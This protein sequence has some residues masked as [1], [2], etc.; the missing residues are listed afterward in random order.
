MAPVSRRMAKPDAFLTD[1]TG[2][3]EVW[4]IALVRVEAEADACPGPSQLTFGGERMLGAAY[5]PVDDQL[6]VGGDVGGNERTQLFL[7]SGDGTSRH[8]ALTNQPEVIHVFGGWQEDGSASSGWS[9]DGTRI[10]YA[11]NAR[12]PRFFDIYERSVD[13]L[14]SHRACCYETTAQLSRALFT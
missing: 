12:D 2:V 13:D 8:T 14:A 10:V 4:S 5:S 7:M 1:I 6:I 9:P 3:A 11:S